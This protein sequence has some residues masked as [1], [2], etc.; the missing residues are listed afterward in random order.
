MVRRWLAWLGPGRAWTLFALLA[1]TGI[2]SLILQAV[3]P[4]TLWVIPVQNVL[5]LVWLLGTVA[6]IVGRLDPLDRRPLLL[7]AGPVVMA[8][9]LG[10]FLPDFMP[11]FVGAGLGWLVVSQA[12]S[13]RHVRREYQQAIRHL[14]RSE[15][16]RAIEVMDALIKAEP[17]DAA[18]YR[19]RAELYRLRGRPKRALEDYRRIV[20]LEPDS[21]VGYNGLAEVCLQEGDLEQALVHARRAYEREPGHW[22]TSYNLGMIEDRLGLASEAALHLGETLRA[23]VSDSRHQLLVHLWLARAYARLDQPEDLERALAALRRHRRG[24]REWQTIFA[25]EQAAT[26]RGILAAD[27]ERARQILDGAGAEA[28]TADLSSNGAEQ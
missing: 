16:D 27:I 19:F 8:L 12:L 20:D 22:V 14:R 18:H 6:V 1:G 26:L 9:A 23:G 25:S 17:E 13:R 28:L 4:A 21:G 5:I 11:W 15:Y 2:I 10:V 7:S 24:L 3:G